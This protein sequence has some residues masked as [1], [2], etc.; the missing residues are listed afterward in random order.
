MS[1][2]L[3]VGGKH[4]YLIPEPKDFNLHPGS[5][6]L[7]Y[8]TKIVLD[9]GCNFGDNEAAI[10]LR[11][12]IEGVI[13]LRLPITKSFV[14]DNKNCI[15]LKKEQGSKEAY[16]LTISADGIVITGGDSPG[17]FY[18]VQTLRQVLRNNSV[19]LPCLTIEDTPYFANRG[20][21]H[22]ITRGKVPTLETLKELV[23]KAASYKINQLQLYIEH[24]FAFKNQTEVW[25]G[26][27]PITAEEI[28]YLDEYCK[29]KHVELVPSLSTFGHLYHLL[30]S[31]SYGHLCE[32][33]SNPDEYFSWVNRM[34]HH[35]VD[36]SNP[37]SLELVQGMLDEFI[38]LFTSD[39][40]NICCD[41]TF[42]LG[43]GKNR[44]LAEKLGKGRLYIDF[45]NKIISYVK[46]YDKKVMFWGDI[47]LEHPEFLSEIPKDVICLNWNYGPDPKEEDTKTIS[48]SGLRQYVCPGVSGW[49]RLMNDMDTASQNIMKMVRHGR[50]YD[51][52]GVL[53]TDWGDYGHIN[54]FENS[55]PGMI[56]GADLSWNPD[57][58]DSIQKADE[59]TSYLELGDKSGSIVGILR[60]LARQQLFEWRFF[61][62]WM[63]GRIQG[64]KARKDFIEALEK[65]TVDEV[66]ES[67]FNALKY[68]DEILRIAVNVPAELKG[69]YEGF[70]VAARGIALFE[71]LFLIVKKY[72][73]GQEL[74]ILIHG[75]KELASLLERWFA[76]YTRIWRRRNKE[77]ELYRIKDVFIE[78][79]NF[80][81]KI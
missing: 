35:T 12:E 2:D 31:N 59:K 67:Y 30:S 19:E 46:K 77:S 69:D 64:L 38:P 63:D 71:S 37:E 60:E 55:M 11:K 6:R 28:L 5:F 20:F 14:R 33:E 24:T 40:F 8:D 15:F 42:D 66:S 32:L 41:E 81:R 49:N 47:I 61:I 27:D 17:L 65:P 1:K 79:C 26:K 58:V 57:G 70:Y 29:K 52:I 3:N 53:N 76:D 72:D 9:A 10:L 4:M 50:K 23:D 25:M 36:V 18:G 48:E 39:K 80:L 54:F 68:G 74:E 45:L 75:P 62:H 21:Y 73:L 16:S 43:E 22:D 7:S 78:L 51:A 56:Y 44:E 13:G 34:H